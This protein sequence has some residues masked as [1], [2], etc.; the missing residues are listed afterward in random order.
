MHIAQIVEHGRRGYRLNA[1]R[2]RTVFLNR[3]G[4]AGKTIAV[5]RLAAITTPMTEKP[6]GCHVASMLVRDGAG[7]VVEF[8]LVQPGAG[9]L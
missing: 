8:Q 3:R 1:F 5:I 2:R 4:S 6:S 7:E 9:P